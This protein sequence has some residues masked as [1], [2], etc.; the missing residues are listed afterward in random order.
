MW[1]EV[2]KRPCPPL[3]LGCQVVF[4]IQMPVRRKNIFHI[5]ALTVG[6]ALRLLH[7]LERIFRLFFC[8]DNG[9]GEGL[10]SSH[11]ERIK[12]NPSAP[13]LCAAALLGRSV[14]RGL[15]FPS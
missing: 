5:E 6:I 15:E 10:R 2:L 8:F 4:T 7:P 11:I 12:G 1:G 14:P 3:E 9:N 13:I